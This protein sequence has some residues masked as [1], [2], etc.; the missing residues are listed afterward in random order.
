MIPIRIV[1]ASVVPPYS[2]SVNF[3][4]L[5]IETIADLECR[6]CLRG[7]GWS[8]SRSDGPR[9]KLLDNTGSY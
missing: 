9:L 4:C 6:S 3:R 5:F 1:Y 2:P 7:R 8:G